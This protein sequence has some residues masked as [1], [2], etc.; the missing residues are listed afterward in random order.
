[1]F[2]MMS[3]QLSTVL[4]FNNIEY[5][6]MMTVP[7]AFLLIS[8]IHT[9]REHYLTRKTL[10]VFFIVP[11]LVSILVFT[12]PWHHLYYAGFHA[13]NIGGVAV[14][15]YE[16]GPLFWIMFVY[17]Y[18]VG[19][20]ALIL[21]AGRLFV[22]ND[23]YRRETLIIL[24]AGC[25]PF[26]FNLAYV[27]HVAPFPE[28]DLTQIAFLLTGIVLAV[29][30]LRYQ[31]FTEVPVA[32]SRVFATISDGVFVI[33]S[34]S[35][36]I[37]LNPAAEG[38]TRTTSNKAMGRNLAVLVPEAA[39]ILGRPGPAPGNR[40][41]EFLLILD[42]QSR[43]YDVLL[44]SLKR[45]G[46]GSNGHLCIFRDVT[47]RKHAELA[48]VIANKKINLLT[49][50]TRHDIENN[51]MIVHGCIALLKKSPPLLCPGGVPGPAG[52]RAECDPGTPRIYPEIPAAWGPSAGL[53]KC[54][55]TGQES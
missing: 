30:L 31:L 23:F 27:F 4:F 28:Y 47:G 20:I 17:N 44:T 5:P 32:Y 13:E 7:V 50:I 41:D 33:D 40:E 2:E 25:F 12:N 18:L 8:I 24:C 21:A 42:G 29:G 48:L 26:S 35:R 54:R 15:V 49:R 3:T 46:I 37:D 38:I 52:N 19:S 6:A 55:G 45:E 43:Y 11:A 51:L 10:T 9:G 34:R 22:R 53:A 39:G 14:W 36:I 16:H 1:M